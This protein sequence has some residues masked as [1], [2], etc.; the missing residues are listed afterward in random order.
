MTRA[1]AARRTVRFTLDA[2]LE[3][4]LEA[5]LAVLAVPHH[6]VIGPHPGSVECPTPG[7]DRRYDPVIG[8]RSAGIP[9]G[10][11]FDDLP[12]DWTCPDCGRPKHHWC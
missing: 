12:D 11:R 10:T 3:A 9:P 8:D 7:C 4:A 1:P 5:A 6:V 2:A